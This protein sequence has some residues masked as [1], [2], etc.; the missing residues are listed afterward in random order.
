MRQNQIK[1]TLL[2]LLAG[3]ALLA[4][5]S[6]R[7]DILPQ[8]S[9]TPCTTNMTVAQFEAFGTDGCSQGDKNY[10]WVDSS[11]N[12]STATISIT[13][14]VQG[15]GD[16]LHNLTITFGQGVAGPFDASFDYIVELNDL[17]TQEG[18]A[19]IDFATFD[20][21]TNNQDQTGLSVIQPNNG[22]PNLVLTSTNGS[23][24]SGPLSK[25][26]TAVQYSNSWTLGSNGAIFFS[27]DTLLETNVRNIPEPASLALFGLGLAALGFVRRRK[28][29]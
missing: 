25:E 14:L 22:T 6:A 1:T 9:S 21:S 29:S 5:G 17:A 10:I 20:P 18:I 2:G 23:A 15:N 24:D 13:E 19:G 11:A 8:P 27:T 16:I 28:S 12:I 7:A 3:A 26:P 4:W